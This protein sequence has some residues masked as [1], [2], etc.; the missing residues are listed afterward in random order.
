V[1][2]A[3]GFAIRPEIREKVTFELHNLITQ[4][5]PRP[6]PAAALPRSRVSWDW[7]LCRNVFIYFERPTIDEVSA[8]L[9]ATLDDDGCL[10]LSATETLS[11]QATGLRL[12][13]A[14][15]SFLYRWRS[16]ISDLGDGADAEIVPAAADVAEWPASIDRLRELL[17]ADDA[18]APRMA[19][20]EGQ[21]VVG[22]PLDETG[23]FRDYLVEPD[24]STPEPELLQRLARAHVASGR[25]AAAE[26]VLDQLLE[27]EPDNVVAHIELGSLLLRTHRFE[28]AAASYDRAHQLAPLLPEIHY[29]Q[30]LVYR[31]L[32]DMQRS[33]QGFRRALFLEPGFWCAAYMLAGVYDRLGMRQRRQSML[34]LTLDWI[35]QRH[36]AQ[37]FTSRVGGLPNVDLDPDEVGAACR[38]ELVPGP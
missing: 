7:I 23:P 20:C 6:L 32:G 22:P 26:T 9:A 8:R 31:K 4:T 34:R 36:I 17:P 19:V 14:G 38:R 2:D 10:M 35:D 13:R 1:P 12:V 21:P 33:L 28:E 27:L 18:P 30:G 37:L 16:D 29:L 15:R 11:P 24:S 3:G 25:H 5:F